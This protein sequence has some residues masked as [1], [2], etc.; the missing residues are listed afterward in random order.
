MIIQAK[1]LKKHKDG[2]I[3]DIC[4]LRKRMKQS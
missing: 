2:Y 1:Q 3:L 4:H